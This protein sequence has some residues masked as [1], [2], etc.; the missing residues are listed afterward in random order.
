VALAPTSRVVCIMA[1]S[2]MQ[3]IISSRFDIFQGQWNKLLCAW[4]RSAN[5]HTPPISLW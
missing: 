2:I 4:S 1:V 5:Y 3:L